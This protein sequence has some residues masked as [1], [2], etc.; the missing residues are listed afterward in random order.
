MQEKAAEQDD[1]DTVIQVESDKA[2]DNIV[3]QREVG[4]SKSSR[5]NAYQLMLDIVSENFTSF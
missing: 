4:E 5:R 1:D 3:I 2:D